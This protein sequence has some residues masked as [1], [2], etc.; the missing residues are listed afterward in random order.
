M[1]REGKCET[2]GAGVCNHTCGVC[3]SYQ[4]VKLTA[5]FRK[6]LKCSVNARQTF[7]LLLKYIT[8]YQYKNNPYPFSPCEV[9]GNCVA[10]A[11]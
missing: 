2:V 9:P 3:V 7:F 10:K 6:S 1:N 11:K 4:L 5:N 8:I